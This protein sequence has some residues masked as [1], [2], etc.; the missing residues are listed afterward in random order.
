[1]LT[2]KVGNWQECHGIHLLRARTNGHDGIQAGHR[3]C[4]V[5]R[6]LL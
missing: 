4:G 6:P 5:Y 1:M 2:I 3:R